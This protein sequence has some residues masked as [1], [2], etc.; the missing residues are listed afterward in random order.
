MP[1]IIMLKNT[2]YKWRVRVGYLA[3]LSALVL[4][5]P[6]L[7]SL[8]WGFV[9]CLLGLFLR[10]WACGHIQ[11]EE[12]LTVSGPYRYTRNPLYLGNLIIGIGLAAS[13]CSWFVFG[14]FCFYFLAFY[15][16]IIKIEK[17]KMEKLFPK[18]YKSFKRV[19]LFIPSLKPKLPPD[20]KKFNWSLFFENKEYRAWI[21]VVLFYVTMIIKMIV[22]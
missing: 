20:K 7:E 16:V 13:S 4:A 12:K 1:G 5:I 21:G 19:P 9:I 17:Q 11:K 22:T 2:I 8:F 3:A 14:I 6:K 15:P 10:T 18:Q